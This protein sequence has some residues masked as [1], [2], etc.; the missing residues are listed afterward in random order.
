M[1]GSGAYYAERT[2]YGSEL[3]DDS[4]VAVMRFEAPLLFS[5][6]LQFKRDVLSVADNIKGFD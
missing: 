2:Y 6:S 4:G 5:N 3:L 1:T